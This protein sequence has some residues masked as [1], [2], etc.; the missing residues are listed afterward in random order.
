[1]NSVSDSL[2]FKAKLNYSQIKGNRKRWAKIAR[3]FEEKTIKESKDTFNLASYD[4][5]NKGLEFWTSKNNKN[6]DTLYSGHITPFLMN[7]LLMLPDSVAAEKLKKIFMI[8]KTAN[9]IEL[10]SYDFQKRFK[11]SKNISDSLIDKYFNTI[12]DIKDDYIKN[13]LSKDKILK[14]KDVIKFY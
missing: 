1:M 12:L 9:K 6:V 14:T 11:L 8:Q 10:A 7:W 3:I 13:M 2:T 4:K 5:Y